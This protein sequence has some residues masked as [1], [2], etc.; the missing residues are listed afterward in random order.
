MTIPTLK[1]STKFSVLFLTPIRNYSVI[2][3]LTQ[4]QVV[5][6]DSLRNAKVTWPIPF[7]VSL[8]FLTE[9]TSLLCQLVLLKAFPL[10]PQ[11]PKPR[12]LGVAPTGLQ[13]FLFLIP[14]QNFILHLARVFGR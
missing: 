5:C 10:M 8:S 1:D 7:K 12:F 3:G 14:R 11:G 2:R 4:T 6:Q 13:K 9:T